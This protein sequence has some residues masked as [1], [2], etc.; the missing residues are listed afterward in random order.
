[1]SKKEKESAPLFFFCIA[2]YLIIGYAMTFTSFLDGSI[3]WYHYVILAPM[4]ILGLLMC[5]YPG[6]YIKSKLID[7]GM[8]E[9][10]ADEV[11][12]GFWFVCLVAWYL[13]VS[14]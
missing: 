14:N 10:K 9:G 1:M 5:V 11:A 8:F 6:I 3:Q 4:G 12:F 13:F 7:W 2:M